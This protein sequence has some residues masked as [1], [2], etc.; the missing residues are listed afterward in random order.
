LLIVWFIIVV[1]FFIVVIVIS[2]GICASLFSG[3]VGALVVIFV[4]LMVAV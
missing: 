1:R 2:V 3:G 4:R